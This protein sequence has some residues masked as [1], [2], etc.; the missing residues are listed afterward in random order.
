[1]KRF[2]QNKIM[3]IEH[4]TRGA[5]C[6]VGSMSAWNSTHLLY[7]MYKPGSQH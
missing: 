2:L 1:M 3:K 5:D 7:L 4:E 6:E